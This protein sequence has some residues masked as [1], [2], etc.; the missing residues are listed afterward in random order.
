MSKRFL[1]YTTLK[2]PLG[3]LRGGIILV[4]SMVLFA[5][6][7]AAQQGWT[8]ISSLKQNDQPATINAVFYDGDNLWL[9]GA[10]GLVMRSTDDGRNFNEVDVGVKEGLNDVFARKDRIWIVGDGGLIVSSTDK[11]KSFSKTTYDANRKG[12]SVPQDKTLDLYSVEFESNDEGYIVGDEG[13]IIHTTDGGRNWLFQA[14]GTKAQ[15]FHLSFLKDE[16]WIVGT[17]GMILHTNDGG[18]SWYPQRSGV[19]VDLNRVF[20]INDKVGLVTGDKGTLLRTDSAGSI[21]QKV[22]TGI[23]EPLFGISFLDKKTGWVVGYQG[24]V[25]RTYDAGLH[26]VDQV[27]NTTIDLFSVSFRDNHGFAIG[28]DGVVMRYF[29]KR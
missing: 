16:G 26:W 19:D 18:Q 15:L 21:W 14:S 11:G 7:I 23:Q 25:I 27:S 6:S 28:R 20:F 29:E 9:V 1:F 2:K 3:D 10:D 13:L 5:I 22:E 17:G 12:L 8:K 4:T 24:R